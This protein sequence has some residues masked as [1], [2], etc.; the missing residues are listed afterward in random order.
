MKN[1][2]LRDFFTGITALIGLGGLA[3]LFLLFGQLAQ[4]TQKNYTVMLHTP[5]TGGLK[6]TSSVTLNGVKI[7]QVRDLSILPGNRGV[8]ITL[9]IRE[10]VTVPR[11]AHPTVESSFVGETVLELTVPTDLSDAQMADTIKP[12]ETVTGLK[13]QTLL[14]RLAEGVSGPLD[15]LGQTADNVDRLAE[16]YT[17]VGERI[18]EMLEP[19]TLADVQ[20][21]KEP[22]VRTAIARLDKALAGADAWL[23]DDEMRTSARGL[24]DKA[25][26][27][28]EQ[29]AGLLGDAKGTLSTVEG[30]AKSIESAAKSL[31][32]T[33]EK[34]GAGVDETLTQAR[35]LLTRVDRAAVELAGILESVNRGEGTAGQLVH[36]PDLYLSLRDAAKRL[37]K[38]LVEVQLV[39]EKLKAEGVKVG[40]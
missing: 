18:A 30:T 22:N 1:T 36:N 4:A 27:A 17:K 29:F 35:A 38:A 5:T 6:E 15:R 39:A 2:T 33:V 11:A 24:I 23:A 7:G 3:G 10:G 25:N 28:I 20:A 40:I 12:G 9:A 37:D 34:T 26:G 16:T 19:R 8:Q 32:E 13:L 14:Q 21:G 31:D